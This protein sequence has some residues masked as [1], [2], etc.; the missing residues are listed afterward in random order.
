MDP[1]IHLFVHEVALIDPVGQS[2]S[3]PL[4][5]RV[6]HRVYHIYQ[7][8][9]LHLFTFQNPHI[10]FIVCQ[11]VSPTSSRKLFKMGELL[12][13]CRHFGVLHEI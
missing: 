1:S 5:G 6:S 7:I 9:D 13:V 8:N 2:R 4:A 12:Q 10:F 3:A 11:R